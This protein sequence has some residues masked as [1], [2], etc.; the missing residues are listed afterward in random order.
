MRGGV[1]CIQELSAEAVGACRDGRGGANQAGQCR[2]GEGS[3]RASFPLSEN[4]AASLGRGLGWAPAHAAAFCGERVARSGGQTQA[5]PR[6]SCR[7]HVK[8]ERRLEAACC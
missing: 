1:I 7:D 3:A 5:R 2:G 8:D 4:A 6:H